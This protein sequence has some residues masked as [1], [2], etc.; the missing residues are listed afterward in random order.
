MKQTWEEITPSLTKLFN[1]SL[2]QEVWKEAEVIFIDKKGTKSDEENFMFISLL[3]VISK[4]L[5]RCVF[6]EM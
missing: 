4:C 5:E 1:K 2:D 3:S 6:L